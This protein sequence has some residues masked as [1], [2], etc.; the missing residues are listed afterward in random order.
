M[1]GPLP[2]GALSA[3]NIT[4]P[5]I[6]KASPGVLYRIL[7]VT[8]PTAAGAIY[9]SASLTG[10]GASNLIDNISIGGG[11]GPTQNYNLE[12]PCQVG[13]VV[14]PGT[15]GVVSVSYT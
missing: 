12:W 9:D 11:A 3:L 14:D 8:V 1:N 5:T 13:I 7:V 2:G 6:V 10:N 4:T 15:G